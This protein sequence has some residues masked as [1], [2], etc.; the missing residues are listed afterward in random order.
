MAR[1][2]HQAGID[3]DLLRLRGQCHDLFAS[4]SYAA[5]HA[6][7]EAGDRIC[8]FSR[9]GDRAAI[10]VAAARLP[11]RA[12]MESWD[13]AAAVPMRRSMDQP[14]RWAKDR[15][16]SR[17][18]RGRRAFPRFACCRPRAGRGLVGAWQK[19]ARDS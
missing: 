3:S 18:I 19:L 12:S 15:G 8:A 16:V 4:G 1:R 7:G 2:P 14:V 6:T 11:Q 9:A 5:L 10:V 13:D 17:S